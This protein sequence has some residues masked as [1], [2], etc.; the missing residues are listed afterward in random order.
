MMQLSYLFILALC[1]SVVHGDCE[2]VADDRPEGCYDEPNIAKIVCFGEDPCVCKDGDS[3]E[4]TSC[5]EIVP[6]DVLLEVTAAEMNGERCR[7]ICEA[8]KKS[9]GNSSKCEYF[10]WEEDPDSGNTTSSHCSLIPAGECRVYSP[11]EGESCMSG[12]AGCTHQDITPPP[13]APCQAGAEFGT[14]DSAVHWAC[15]NPFDQEGRHVDIYGTEEIPSGTI[16]STVHRCESFDDGKDDIDTDTNTPKNDFVFRNLVVQCNDATLDTPVIDGT[17]VRYSQ[18]DNDVA[19]V[20]TEDTPNKLNDTAC[21]D[22]PD[23]L[24]LDEAKVHK[25]G[26]TLICS[27]QDPDHF[28]FT[29]SQ[30]TIKK[31]NTCALLCNFRH[32]LTIEPKLL[33]DGASRWWVYRAGDGSRGVEAVGKEDQ[34]NIYCW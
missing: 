30:V 23:D 24:V 9:E 4:D 5:T 22:K 6:A 34:T 2:D 3:G 11:C 14:G 1:V 20:I 15:V 12:Q 31:G 16:C 13:G 33:P 18:S 7:G 26:V 10:R 8:S 29:A 19:A 17:W 27:Q 21:N 32:V 28:V 25:S